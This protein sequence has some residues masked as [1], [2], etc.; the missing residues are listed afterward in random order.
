M[1]ATERFLPSETEVRP[2]PSMGI[3]D[4]QDRHA[5][6]AYPFANIGVDASGLIRRLSD[7]EWVT[8]RNKAR[9]SDRDRQRVTDPGP[10]GA[11]CASGFSIAVTSVSL[12]IEAYYLLSNT[13]CNAAFLRPVVT[14]YAISGDASGLPLLS[15]LCILTV[16][17]A[18]TSIFLLPGPSHDDLG[19]G[20]G[21]PSRLL[22]RVCP[23]PPI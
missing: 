2:D 1:Y 21:A 4:V 12:L 11:A 9:H 10:S 18:Y 20:P 19:G 22:D 15:V 23:L 13:P 7:G 16:G 8:F 3:H 6:S 5:L 17:A 14:E